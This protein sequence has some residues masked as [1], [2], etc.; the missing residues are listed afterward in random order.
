MRL[1]SPILLSKVASDVLEHYKSQSTIYFHWPFCKN[2]CTYCNFNKYVQSEKTFG[3]DFDVLMK[4]SLLKETETLLKLSGVSTI[5]SVYFGG[6]TPSLAPSG[7]ISSLLQNIKNLCDLSAKT[8]ISVEC[9]PS[10][11]NML[12]LLNEY[13]NC[14]VN[15]V[16]IGL[17][18]CS[19]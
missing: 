17:Q 10:S 18:V 9:N 5:N 15:R 6:G 19:S 2:L 12:G 3:S 14:G 11:F 4:N 8:E 13:S 7:T 1:P 16:S